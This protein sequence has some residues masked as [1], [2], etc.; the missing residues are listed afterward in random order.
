MNKNIEILIH[1]L[2]IALFFIASASFNQSEVCA[3]DDDY[4]KIRQEDFYKD[5]DSTSSLYQDPASDENQTRQEDLYQD[6]D[7]T[8]NIY[9]PDSDEQREERRRDIY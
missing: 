6:K 1:A 5:T 8:S 3:A 2:L 9:Q 4:D 7:S